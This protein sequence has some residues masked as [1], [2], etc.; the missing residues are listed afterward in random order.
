MKLYNTFVKNVLRAKFRP[1]QKGGNTDEVC[2]Q[3]NP[4]GKIGRSAT[5]KNWL[6]LPP[7]GKIGADLVDVSSHAAT[8]KVELEEVPSKTK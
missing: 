7:P 6:Q 3:L 8:D 4:G 1:S 2:N 5:I